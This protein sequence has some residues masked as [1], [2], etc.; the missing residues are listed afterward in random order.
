[1]LKSPTLLLDKETAI[2]NMERMAAKAKA[3]DIV[4]RPH[5]KTHQSA[6]A[7]EWFRKFE[8]KS[9]TVSSVK[10]ASYF[11]SNGWK[12][13]TV[14]FPVNIREWKEINDLAGR[15]KL[16]ILVENTEAVAFLE[17]RLSNS[18]GA[19]I[20]VDTGYG[21]TGVDAANTGALQ[22]LL[23]RLKKGK[24][25][26]FKGFL[27]HAGH[28]YHAASVDE[29]KEIKKDAVSALLALKN[30]FR[31]EYPLLQLSYGDTPSCSVCDDFSDVDEL[32]PGNFIFYDEMQYMLGACSRNDIAVALASP[33]VAKHAERN[34]IVIHGGAV[35]LSKESIK[36]KNGEKY[37]G[38]VVT[39]NGYSWDVQNILGEMTA[40]SQ[41]HGIVKVKNRQI[42]NDI[43]TGDMVAVLP[44]HSCLTANLM[45]TYTTTSGE[46]I[47]MMK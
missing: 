38:T 27:T 30:F 1:M 12:D 2:R 46:K 23:N 7:G 3:S 40:L 9:I 13:I 32:R 20:K 41:E 47:E 4:F 17:K 10:M 28:T 8:V 25:L 33:V 11:A 15:I 5:F 24:K 22:V 18:A 44:V 21:R 43:Q 14:A 6:E 29:I 26:E 35:H 42:F 39:L 45:K 37:F 31:H 36:N 16:N 19:F 34:E